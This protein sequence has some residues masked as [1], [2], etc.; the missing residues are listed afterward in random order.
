MLDLWLGQVKGKQAVQDGPGLAALLAPDLTQTFL[1]LNQSLN[2][3]PSLRPAS[4]TSHTRSFFPEYRPFADFLAA[5]L[6]L[7]RDGNLE[8]DDVEG[9][10][11]TYQLVEDCFRQADKVFAQ[12]DTGWFV[13]TL[14]QL[15]RRLIDLGLRAGRRAGDTKLTKAGEA[16]R[17]LGRPMGIAASD[18]SS[19]SPSKKDA[20]FFLANSTF[21]VY[22]AMS[23]LRL[24]DTIL[25]NT[26]NAAVSLDSSYPKSDR[27]AFTYY[28]GRLFLYQR[29]LPQA[30]AA[31][32]K[33]F[34]L[35]QV[36]NWGNGRLILIYLIAAS[37][38]LGIFPSLSLLQE[39]DLDDQYSALL[40]A[41]KLGD[42][43]TVLSEL[44]RHMS[45]HLKKGNYLLL[46][47]KLEV[48]CWRNLARRTLFVV[49]KGRPQPPTGPPTLSLH[50]LVTTARIAFSDPS[51]DVDDVESMC[52]SLM[53]QG[54][55]KA[56]IMHSKRL[57]VLQKGDA[58]GFPRIASV[59]T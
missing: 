44:H 45:W 36:E 10:E 52:S 43:N 31:L 48:I 1:T 4:F 20:L 18:R 16:A 28:R 12:G 59:N 35:C 25:N 37:L 6:L 24:C 17:M 7:V 22:F 30:R 57:L 54:Y 32:Q 39:F 55:I 3:T 33:A 29:R 2:N 8:A 34:K 53:D 26:Q 38:P 23:N 21:K 49:T 19:D 40:A 13:P 50:A 14:R 9:L 41:L 11:A 15:T 42:F 51:L 27:V 46:K 58:Y 5:F 47:E 56:Y